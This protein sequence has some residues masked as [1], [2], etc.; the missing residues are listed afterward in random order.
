MD[1][2]ANPL[3]TFWHVTLPS[4][5]LALIAAVLLGLTLSFDEV[6][7]TFFLVGEKLT[8]PMEIWTRI[9]FGFTPEINAIFTIIV[10]GSI[11][12]ALVAALLSLGAF[13]RRRSA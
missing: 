12:L 1:L 3:R 5:R 11:I 2:G 4:I 13:G 9:R 10:F 6:I 8:L 7:I